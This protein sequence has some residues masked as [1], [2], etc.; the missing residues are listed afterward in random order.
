MDSISKINSYKIQTILITAT[1][2]KEV[3]ELL[4][5]KLSLESSR[6]I[7]GNIERDNIAYTVEEVDPEKGIIKTFDSYLATKVYPTI[8]PGEKIIIFINSEAKVNDLAN[9][10][11]LPRYYANYEGKTEDFNRFKDNDTEYIIV[12]TSALSHGINIPNIRYIIHLG[13]LYSLIDYIQETGRGGRDGKPSKGVIFTNT[14]FYSLKNKELPTF[15]K[16][17]Q[18]FKEIDRYF[19]DLFINERICRR[20][21]INRYLNTTPIEECSNTRNKCDLCEKRSTIYNTKATIELERSSTKRIAI[22]N[23]KEKTS[24]I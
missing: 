2:T 1:Y 24:Y 11:G 22:N 9:K 6:L 23:F 5:I 15:N 17:F 20:R 10:Y 13:E 21:I 3:E 14:S 19:L 8:K 7:K 18:S 4:S 12:S 16:T